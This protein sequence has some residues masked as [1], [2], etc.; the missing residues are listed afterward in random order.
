MFYL[1]R[2]SHECK[3]GSSHLP[4]HG[5][6]LRY[7]AGDQILNADMLIQ[8]WAM[9]IITC[10]ILFWSIILPHGIDLSSSLH[11]YICGG[12]SVDCGG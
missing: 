3:D 6:L 9:F 1:A 11:G 4:A 2:S 7:E 5:R 12:G 8:K 10:S